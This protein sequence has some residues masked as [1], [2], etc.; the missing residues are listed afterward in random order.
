MI[1]SRLSYILVV[2][3]C[4]LP[5]SVRA[6]DVFQEVMNGRKCKESYN[7]VDCTYTIGDSLEI[8]IAGIG[9]SDTGI[10]FIR[11][12]FNGDYYASFGLLHQCVIVKTGEKAGKNATME[13]AFISSKNG[14]VYKDWQ[15][16]AKRN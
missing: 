2:F 1:A 14:K 3:L 15:E 6:L 10:T 11:S 4:I 7:G 13:I 5:V 8:V 16:C 9:R 12:D